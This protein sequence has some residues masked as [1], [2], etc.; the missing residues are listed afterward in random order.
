MKIFG[1]SIDKITKGPNGQRQF[2]C[3]WCKRIKTP[4]LIVFA[5]HL[6]GWHQDKINDNAKITERKAFKILGD[7]LAGDRKTIPREFRHNEKSQAP[8][9]M[10][11]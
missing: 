5:M 4:S 2:V 11:T 3:P 9:H 7:Y 1:L 6:T 8:T 10:W